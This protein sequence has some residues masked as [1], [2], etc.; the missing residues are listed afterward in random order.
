[1]LSCRWMRV[2]V[3]D[4]HGTWLAFA[5][6]VLEATVFFIVP[7]VLLTWIGM[8]RVKPALVAALAATA[9]AMIG[10]IVMFE[11]GRHAPD[12]AHALLRSVPGIDAGLVADVRT[13]L[14]AHG[15]VA[16]LR[17]LV[18]GRPY[19]IFAVESGAS[20]AGLATF[21]VVSA[22]ARTLRFVVSVFLARAITLGLGRWTRK[23]P[24][25]EVTAWAV[26][27]VGFYSFYFAT[28]GW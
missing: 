18:R 19:K 14:D 20:S 4:R 22:F 3:S 11:A 2:K 23:R 16:L 12:A 17:G 6:G 26:F 1:M 10:G 21:L 27:W 15:N 5:W 13:E 28:F 24:R 25:L 8:Q 9:G 7:D